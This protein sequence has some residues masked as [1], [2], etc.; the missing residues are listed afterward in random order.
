L[1]VGDGLSIDERDTSGA[2][3]AVGSVDGGNA[4]SRFD[5]FDEFLINGGVI[6]DDEG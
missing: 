6:A 3:R 2:S 4:Q 1:G 5:R